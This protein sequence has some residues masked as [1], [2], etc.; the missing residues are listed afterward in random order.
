MGHEPSKYATPVSVRGSV[1]LRPLRG[2]AGSDVR[3]P[4]LGSPPSVSALT[5]MGA[6]AGAYVRNNGNGPDQS[7]GVA[8]IFTGL[9]P[10]ASGTLGLRFPIA[11]AV[12]QYWTAAD[13]ASL[14]QAIAGNVLTL[15]WTATRTLNSNERVIVAYQWA[16]SS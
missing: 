13:W 11:P 4:D 14:T 16:V 8:V 10:A 2:P 5:G 12:N 6:G 9:A 7:Q 3:Q 1:G 15:T